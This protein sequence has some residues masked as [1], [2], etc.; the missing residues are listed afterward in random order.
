MPDE[1]ADAF[2]TFAA[3]LRPDPIEVDETRLLRGGVARALLGSPRVDR[4]LDTGSFAHGTAVA[5]HSRLD[6]LVV[7][8]GARPR[9]PARSLDALSAALVE[10][11]GAAG[12]ASRG[13]GG[14]PT[15]QGN[16]DSLLVDRPGTAGLRLMPAYA[17]GGTRSGATSAGEGQGD[18]LWVL[19]A[20]R[21]WVRHLPA[22][23]E[24]LLSRI[25]ADGSLRSLVR[26]LLI[27]KHRQGIDISSYYLE[28]VAIRQALQQNSF[29]PL[30]DVCWAW[31]RLAGDGLAPV[32]DLT[33]PSGV[34]A[35]RPSASLARSIESQFA[36]ERAASSA[37][38]AVDSY[39][40]GDVETSGRYLRALF[41]PGFPD[42]AS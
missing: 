3:A 18:A 27:W 30:W 20:S 31:E 23:R 24:M 25:D 6:L 37:R 4:V 8:G 22:A 26:L 28:T 13:L 38:A 7:L 1:I 10:G 15:R 32:P 16:G 29:S 34:Q 11:A 5:G 33:S 21:R 39:L 40:D 12:A 19:D 9:T 41:G 36:L 35:V 2:T 14:F 42:P 17:A